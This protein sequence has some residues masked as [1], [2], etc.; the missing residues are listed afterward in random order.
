MKL[1]CDC[2]ALTSLTLQLSG[3]T[4]GLQL[5]LQLAA[6]PDALVNSAS[7]RRFG[8]SPKA[9]S[10]LRVQPAPGGEERLNLSWVGLDYAETKLCGELVPSVE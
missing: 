7:V 4:A 6:L 1:V 5:S 3:Q 2:T 8:E 10:P 9:F